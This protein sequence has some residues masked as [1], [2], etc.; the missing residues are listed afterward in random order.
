MILIK[1]N[2]FIIMIIKSSKKKYDF[3]RIPIYLMVDSVLIEFKPRII[4]FGLVQLH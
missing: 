4:D 3:I 2:N 1:I